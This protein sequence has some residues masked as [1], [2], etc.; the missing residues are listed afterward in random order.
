VVHIVTIR[1]EMV[2]IQILLPKLKDV[3][4]VSIIIMAK[5]QEINSNICSPIKYSVQLSFV[6]R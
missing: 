3:L 2:K 6:Q 4:E 1:L 5:V